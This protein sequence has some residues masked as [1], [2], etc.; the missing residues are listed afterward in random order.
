[1]P[2]KFAGLDADVEQ[3]ADVKQSAAIGLVTRTLT[4]M[5]GGW[6]GGALAQEEQ[7]QRRIPAGTS[8]VRRRIPVSFRRCHCRYN[9]LQH[10]LRYNTRS[11]V[12]TGGAVKS[13]TK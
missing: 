5:Q 1:M 11:V 4:D 3:D 12:G 8:A 6:T 10:A 9:T 2:A 7:N 13:T